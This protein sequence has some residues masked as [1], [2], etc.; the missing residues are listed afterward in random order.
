MPIRNMSCSIPSGNIYI[1]PA[2]S[3]KQST[4]PAGAGFPQ[5]NLTNNDNA[6]TIPACAIKYKLAEKVLANA[7]ARAGGVACVSYWVEDCTVTMDIQSQKASN[8][9]IALLGRNSFTAS[10]AVTNEEKIIEKN[11][12]NAVAPNGSVFVPL[13]RVPDWTVN[14]VV[15]N[16]AGSTTYVLGTDYTLGETGILVP[17]SSTIVSA[18]SP[19]TTATLRVSYTALDTLR[20]DALVY[21]PQDVSILCDGFDRATGAPIQTWIYQAKGMADGMP[22]VA[23]D[24]LKFAMTF[25]ITADTRIPF[26]AAAPVSQYFHQLRG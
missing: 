16:L 1:G 8:L 23:D 19:F 25:R 15:T 5:M 13:N 21:T 4:L 22:I 14:P 26:N 9:A 3:L 7:N 6:G 24:Y 20:T 2:G 18:S 17:V 10:G 11:A 12:V